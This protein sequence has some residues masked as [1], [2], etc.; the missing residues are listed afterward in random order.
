MKE[1]WILA[2]ASLM[3]LDALL[4]APSHVFCQSTQANAAGNEK[5]SAV[6]DISG[7]WSTPGFRH[8]ERE[9][10]PDIPVIGLTRFNRKDYPFRPGGDAL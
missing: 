8:I 10:L 6:P 4:L 3:L 5:R 1:R 7:V 9:Q 2:C